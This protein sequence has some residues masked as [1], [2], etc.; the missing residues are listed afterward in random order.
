LAGRARAVASLLL[1]LGA[2]WAPELAA[3]R[4]RPILLDIGPNDADYVRGFRED[5][6]PDGRTRFRWAGPV[7]EIRI[8]LHVRGDGHV[9]RLRV[10][11]HFVEPAQVRLTTEGRTAAVFDIQA[12]PTTPYRILEF[13]LPRLEGRE[14]FALALRAASERA[15]AWSLAFDW[16]EIERRAPSAR[17]GLLV[18]TRVLVALAVLIAF[19]APWLA[20]LDARWALAHALAMTGGAMWAAYADVLAIERILREGI[21]VYAATALIAV[22]LVRRPRARQALGVA[23]P[24]VAGGLVL[25]VMVAL[26]VRLAMLLHP[27]FYYPDVRVHAQFAWEL[28]RRG[29]VAF[30]RNFTENQ[31]RYSLGL[32]LEN[33]HWYAFPYPPAFYILCWPLVRLGV[34][35]EVAVSVLAAAVNSLEALLVFGIARRLQRAEGLALAAAAA[36][37]VL[38]LFL[39][40]LSLAYFPALVG[41][42]VDAVVLLYLVGHLNDLDR[43]RVVLTLGALLAAAFLTYTQSL[44]NFAVLLPIFL[45]FQLVRDRTREGRHRQFGLVAAGLLGATLSL[46]VFYGRYVPIV[47]DMRRGIPMAEERVLIEKQEQQ[48]RNAVRAGTPLPAPAA[49]DDP[50]TGPQVDLVRGLRKA[51]WRLYVF[52]GLFAPVAVAGVLLAWRTTGGRD[53]ARLVAAWALTYLV[54]NLASGALPGPNLVRYNKDLEIIAPLCCLG[55]A[56][57]GAWLWTLTR[58]GAV[59]YGAAFWLFGLARARSYLVDR[60]WLD[61]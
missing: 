10:R 14:P 59:A 47:L 40:R 4:A 11:R 9:L 17:F 8:P 60:L 42:G 50:Y 30:L 28:G 32:Q 54:L 57:V 20:G 26:A 36:V 23:T 58:A 52:Y 7:A 45:L 35:P 61:R 55:L 25:L 1:A 29:L 22:A 13:P 46:L 44:L 37:P 12:D 5:W 19:L 15:G 27:R 34:R 49:D 39:A 41:H 24:W 18:S 21:A 33:G 43:R 53:A 48:A 16:L 56:S 51:A 38:P 2:W 3:R 31:Y 6:E